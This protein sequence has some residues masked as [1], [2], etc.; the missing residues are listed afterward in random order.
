MTP[1]KTNTVK[2]W[3]NLFS[4]KFIR[5]TGETQRE[6]L[7]SI[8]LQVEEIHELKLKKNATILSHYYMPPELQIETKDGG[9]ADHTGDSLA[10][11]V[12]GTQTE[13]EHIVFCG[14]KFMA[15]TAHILSQGKKVFLP[16]WLAG[17]TLAESITAED[18]KM[19]RAKH[20][21]VPVMAYIN[22]NA[23]TK[24]ECDI[25]CTSRNAIKI[26]N[27]FSGEELIFVP[28]KY[29]GQ[30]LVSKAGGET[31][32]KFILWNGSCV[33]HEQ[34][35]GNIKSMTMA[36]PEAE[37]LLHW[38]VPGQTVDSVLNSTKGIVGSTS[39]IIKY[40]EDSAAKKFILGSECDLGA[41]LKGK[42]PLKQFITP[43]IYCSYMK[44]ITIGNTLETL[45][46]IGTAREKEQ[47]IIMD[48]DLRTRAFI[49][50]QRMLDLS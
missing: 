42:F 31:N 45:K 33:V 12:A 27:T 34:F 25:I 17:C 44:A 19:L 50:L 39:D 47:L 11:S 9:V 13:A 15:E 23:E 2:N 48:E 4:E 24:A 35:M 41:T 43:C 5:M 1:I 46:M 32:K 49:P 22:T 26:A 20:P 29:M 18:V 10:L 8:L 37:V 3:K 21:G 36:E 40:V 7:S 6:Q 30:N 38:E 16:S 14:V 28:D